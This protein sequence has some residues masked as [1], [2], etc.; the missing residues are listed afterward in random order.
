MLKDLHVRN[1]WWMGEK[2]LSEKKLT[3]KEHTSVL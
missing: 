1:G 2:D 3:I